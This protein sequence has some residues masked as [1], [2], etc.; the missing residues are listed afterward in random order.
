M[1]HL[2]AALCIRSSALES[3]RWPCP[4]GPRLWLPRIPH[5]AQARQ[6]LLPPPWVR[7]RL[8]QKFI[9]IENHKSQDQHAASVFQVTH[10]PAFPLPCSRRHS[11][12]HSSP[13]RHLPRHPYLM[14]PSGVRSETFLSLPIPSV[15]Y[16][17]HRW[18]I[19]GW[20]KSSFR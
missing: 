10:S 19:L 3:S 12:T 4:C 1:S 18:F 20:P 7:W 5:Q 8:M 16:C 6:T 2:G 14:P 9:D 11:V 15:F 17:E 13:G